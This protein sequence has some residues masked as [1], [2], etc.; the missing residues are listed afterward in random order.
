MAN[1]DPI[2][3]IERLAKDGFSLCES[4]CADN[5]KMVLR[6]ESG[7]AIAGFFCVV[8]SVLAE[9]IGRLVDEHDKEL[10]NESISGRIK[11]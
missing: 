5:I 2:K 11:L 4:L 9:K 6:E 1:K 3:K 7:E 8:D 10:D